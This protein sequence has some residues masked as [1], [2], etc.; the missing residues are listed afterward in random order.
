[1]NLPLFEDL[2]LRNNGRKIGLLIT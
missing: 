2:Q 1:M